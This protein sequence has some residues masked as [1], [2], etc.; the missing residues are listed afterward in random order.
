M[1]NKVTACDKNMFDKIREFKEQVN[2]NLKK[3]VQHCKNL[4]AST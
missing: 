2:Q 4:T 1:R 3:T